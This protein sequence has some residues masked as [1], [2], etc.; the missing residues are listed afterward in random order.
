MAE[1]TATTNAGESLATAVRPG[2]HRN[3]KLG[4]VVSTK[5]SKTIVVAV[6]RRVSHSLYKR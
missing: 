6:T 5:M 3:E 1:E 4:E 2:D